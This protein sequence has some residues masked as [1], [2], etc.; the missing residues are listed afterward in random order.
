MN[1]RRDMN[2]VQ[3]QEEG[4]SAHEQQ[5]KKIEK[6]QDLPQTRLFMNIDHLPP[7]LSLFLSRGSVSICG[8]FMCFSQLVT[9]TSQFPLVFL[10]VCVS[11]DPHQ[12][13][14]GRETAGF[15]FWRVLAIVPWSLWISTHQLL[16]LS[17]WQTRHTSL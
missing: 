6:N 2:K 1:Q 12:A 3:E 5:R 14:A 10:F 7:S 16:S 15:V 4:T 11:S 8:L 9:N 13:R 17:T